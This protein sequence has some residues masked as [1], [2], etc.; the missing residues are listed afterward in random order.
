MSKCKN[1]HEF[2]FPAY[3]DTKLDKKVDQK[4]TNELR[5]ARFTNNLPANSQVETYA[6]T[7]SIPICPRCAEP[8]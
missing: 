6:L 7:A 5:H 1:G 3:T 8:L 4:N 2:E